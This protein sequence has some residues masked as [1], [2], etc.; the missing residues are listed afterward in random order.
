MLPPSVHA[1]DLHDVSAQNVIHDSADHASDDAESGNAV[2]QMLQTIP[3]SAAS[4]QELSL[5]V[6]EMCVSQQQMHMNQQ[7]IRSE[8]AAI[9]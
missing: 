2:D 8:M 7:Q 9:Q 5:C 6:R 4:M 3:T 1:N